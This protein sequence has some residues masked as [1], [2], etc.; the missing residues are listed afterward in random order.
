[1]LFVDNTKVGREPCLKN[2]QTDNNLVHFSHKQIF[3][4]SL[5]IKSSDINPISENILNDNKANILSMFNY[6]DTEIRIVYGLILHYPNLNAVLVGNY[7]I[8]EFCKKHIQWKCNLISTA[9][10]QIR[11]PW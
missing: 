8:P 11:L 1:M 9:N 6:C 7:A 4:E 5:S 3:I 2:G 10:Y